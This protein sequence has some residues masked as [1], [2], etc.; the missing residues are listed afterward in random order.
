[1]PAGATDGVANRLDL[2]LNKNALRLATESVQ[3]TE[4]CMAGP[5]RA[6]VCPPSATS[7]R[8]IQVGVP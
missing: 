4:P 8:R 2:R 1:M 7:W 5:I 3:S 6:L